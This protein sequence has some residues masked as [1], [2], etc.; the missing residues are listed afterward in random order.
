VR[1]APTVY[2]PVNDLDSPRLRAAANISR[3]QIAEGLALLPENRHRKARKFTVAVPHDPVIF[4][5]WNAD[6]DESISRDLRM[7]CRKVTAIGHSSSLVQMWLEQSPPAPNLF[8]SNSPTARYRLRVTCSGRLADLDA[9]FNREEWNEYRMLQSDLEAS[10]GKKKGEIK[11]RIVARFG[12]SQPS[13]RRPTASLWQGYDAVKQATPQISAEGTCFDPQ[14]I[15]LG[16]VGGLPIALESTLQVTRALRDT[17]MAN[18][19]VQPP[20]EWISGHGDNGSPSTTHHLAF[21][22]LGYVGREH[23]DGH[24]LGLGIAVP[25]SIGVEESTRC[26]R[27]LLFDEFGFARP[28]L[29]LRL[30]QLGVWRVELKEGDA[31]AVA[32][33][34]ETWTGANLGGAKRWA[35]VTPI[36]LDQHPRG[37]DKWSQIEQTIAR[38][39]ERIGLPAPIDIILSSTSM[40]IG[41]PNGHAF[42]RLK[43]KNGGTINHTHAILTFDKPVVGPILLGAGRYRGYGFCRPLLEE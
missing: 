19:P 25:K 26:W 28:P 16:R 23:A 13:F 6:L 18:C 41:A 21:L 14:L 1:S 22:P 43:R 38:A 40:F 24:L 30:G 5:H 3:S 10:K 9:R 15:I 31:S 8:P 39:C 37:A 4:L 42:P 35:T 12:S 11:T 32:L 27:G 20:P 29:E 34:S 17:L 2:V 33:R 7:L 36:S